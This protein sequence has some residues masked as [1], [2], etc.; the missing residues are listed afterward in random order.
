MPIHMS[1]QMSVNNSVQTS[2]EFVSIT[3]DVFLH[4]ATFGEECLC[5]DMRKDMC[6]QV[7]GHVH[8]RAY[9]HQYV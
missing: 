3:L 6:T 8:G 1:I 7:Y 4:T 2:T 5:T 9:C